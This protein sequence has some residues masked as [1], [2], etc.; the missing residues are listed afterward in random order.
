MA[1]LFPRAELE[2][3][4][5]ELEPSS[6]ATLAALTRLMR[7]QSVWRSGAISALTES[8]L[9]QSF[10]EQVFAEV[11]GYA[12][13]FASTQE[14]YSSLPKIYVP[15]PGGRAF[16]DLALGW[17]RSD[18]QQAVVT[19]ELKGPGADLDRAQGGNYGGKTPVAQ[20]LEAASAAG[21]TWC[22]VSNMDECR[23]YR[24]PTAQ[25]FETI[26]LTEIDSPHS[27]RRAVALFSS[28]S[29]LGRAPDQPGA[30]TK[31]DQQLQRG[32]SMIVPPSPGNIR[33][34]QRVRP[35]T[36]H[37]VFPFA[38]LNVQLQK[39]FEA[40]PDLARIDQDVHIPRLGDE[41][42]SIDRNTGPRVWQRISVNKA[43]VLVCS[44]LLGDGAAPNIFVEQAS[45]AH[46][47]AQYISFAWT[48]FESLRPKAL[49]FEWELED[50]TADTAVNGGDGL[51]GWPVGVRLKCQQGVTRTSYPGVSWSH[52]RG[53]SKDDVHRTVEEVVSELLFPFDGKDDDGRLWRTSFAPGKLLEYL[54]GRNLLARFP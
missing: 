45:M 40:V 20:A 23:L 8:N 30:L 37:G 49:L 28:R 6:E 24:V 46:D 33:L 9:E 38:R 47:I 10:N 43:G 1:A 35:A 51:R 54:N 27:F 2:L 44:N 4:A 42:L 48:F 5:F 11:F 17:F 52:E 7:L 3:L 39:A 13:I 41:V 12:S 15:I 18:M 22:I 32:T 34:I 21:A 31:L 25:D 19:A 26:R 50:L 53:I 14:D 16:P 29:L 36:L